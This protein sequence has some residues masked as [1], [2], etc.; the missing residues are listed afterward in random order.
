M[1]KLRPSAQSWD[2]KGERLSEGTERREQSLL[3][4]PAQGKA[5]AEEGRHGRGAGPAWRLQREEPAPEAWGG[6]DL[7]QKWGFVLRARR[8][9]H[10]ALSKGKGW[11]GGGRDILR[12]PRPPKIL[13]W[14]AP[15]L[16]P[17]CPAPPPLLPL[18]VSVA[19]RGF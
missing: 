3:G 19:T 12:G 13:C 5:L 8:S 9:Y 1:G 18:P 10:R 7:Q 11:G 6:R 17:G 4:G 2:L 16:N 14:G 15:S